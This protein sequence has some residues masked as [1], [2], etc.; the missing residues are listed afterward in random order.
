MRLSELKG[1]YVY[2]ECRFMLLLVTDVL[3]NGD[4]K[5]ISLENGSEITL[6][7]RSAN[8]DIWHPSII[9]GMYDG[10]DY[11]KFANSIDL[12][13]DNDFSTKFNLRMDNAVTIMDVKNPISEIDSQINKMLESKDEIFINFELEGGM[14]SLVEEIQAH[15]VVKAVKYT[16]EFGAPVVTYLPLASIIGMKYSEI[17]VDIHVV[18]NFATICYANAIYASFDMFPGVMPIV[19]EQYT[20]TAHI[21]SFNTAAKS[22]CG[23]YDHCY[24]QFA[25]YGIFRVDYSNG[26]LDT[27]Y[28][29]DRL[30]LPHDTSVPWFIVRDDLVDYWMRHDSDLKSFVTGETEKEEE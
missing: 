22:M 12:F 5:A 16:N 25:K 9:N 2:N 24:F 13:L 4:C 19:Y 20:E 21:H 27:V 30:K 8:K 1:M 11:A 10:S 6:K 26:K 14:L 23:K 29:K 28:C 3:E 18:N 7:A 17:N 15:Y